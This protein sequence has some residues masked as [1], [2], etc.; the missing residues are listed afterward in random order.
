MSYFAI[1][2]EIKE[3]QKHPNADKLMIAKVFGSNIIVG[4]DSFENQK[5][6]YFPSDGQLSH[7]FCYNN[8][9]YRHSNL[10]KNPDVIGYIEDNRRVRIIKLRGVASDGLIMSLTSLNYLKVNTDTLTIGTQFNEVSGRLIC[11]K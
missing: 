1:I 5:V 3:L 9:L 6:I 4:T 11:N 8:N 2:T 7:D 10:N